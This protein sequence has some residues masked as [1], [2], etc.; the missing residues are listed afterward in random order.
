MAT[1]ILKIIGK[2]VPPIEL[3]HIATPTTQS[4]S[5]SEDF[6]HHT[7]VGHIHA[8]PL[9]F[10]NQCEMTPTV[11]AKISPDETWSIHVYSKSR[12][13]VRKGLTPSKIP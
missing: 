13:F 2:M 11:G 8:N 4:R 12:K 7:G 3:P 5:E 9:R 6:D 10:L 1:R